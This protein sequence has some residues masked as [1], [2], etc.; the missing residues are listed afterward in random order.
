V[1]TSYTGIKNVPEHMTKL[2]SVL[3]TANVFS[4]PVL[5]VHIDTYGKNNKKP[6]IICGTMSLLHDLVTHD[7]YMTN[8]VDVM[9]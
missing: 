5:V 2:L 1:V 4:I 8:F 9:L 7:Y 3:S 6:R